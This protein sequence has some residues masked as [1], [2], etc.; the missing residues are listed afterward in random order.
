MKC[1]RLDAAF[2]GALRR[3]FACVSFEVTAD[4]FQTGYWVIQGGILDYRAI[5]TET[6]YL[7]F[8]SAA[9]VRALVP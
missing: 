4:E 5:E 3:T 6:P 2:L 9:Y 7:L 8:S 1:S